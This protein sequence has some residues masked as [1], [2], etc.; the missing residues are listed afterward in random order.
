MKEFENFFD[1]TIKVTA[2]AIFRDFQKFV[3]RSRVFFWYFQ[4]KFW[5]LQRTVPFEGL[6]Y[7]Q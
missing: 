1:F 7:K 6:I 3:I 4:Q 2:N 5:L